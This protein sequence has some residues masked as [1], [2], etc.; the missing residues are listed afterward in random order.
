MNKLD[1]KRLSQRLGQYL[2]WGYTSNDAFL[3]KILSRKVRG[4]GVCPRE[5]NSNCDTG[6]GNTLER[7]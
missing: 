5:Q 6:S 2:L 3:G 1:T 7:S 4:S